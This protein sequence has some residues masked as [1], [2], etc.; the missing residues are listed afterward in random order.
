MPAPSGHHVD[1]E[2]KRVVFTAERG[3]SGTVL[4][5]AIADMFDADPRTCFYDFI[6]EC[7]GQ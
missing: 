7:T 6:V 5:Q 3:F 2:R 4:S 1:H